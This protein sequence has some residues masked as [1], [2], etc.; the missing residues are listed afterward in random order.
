MESTTCTLL[1]SPIGPLLVASREGGLAEIRF[2]GRRE[3]LPPGWQYVDA[4][5][6][7]AVPQLRAYFA[8]ELRTFDLPLAPEG[9]PFQRAV[10]EALRAI[11]YGTTCSYADLARRIGRP[12]AV[13]AVGAANGKNPLPIVVPCHRVIGSDGTL[14]GYAGG[15]SVKR[16]LL[17][18]EGLTFPEPQRQMVLFG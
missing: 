2:N 15:L 8:G 5:E 6:G 10:W 1:D 7:D 13:R 3:A 11:P 14:T 16:A 9:T 4:L 12:A 18:L 17:A